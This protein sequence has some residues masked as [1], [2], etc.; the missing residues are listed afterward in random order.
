MIRNG[1]GCR[2]ARRRGLDMTEAVDILDQTTNYA[3]LGAAPG[4]A[5][6][7]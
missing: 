7:K 6:G 5:Q 2:R 4:T 1:S 3:T